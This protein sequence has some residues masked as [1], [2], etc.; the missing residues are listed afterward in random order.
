M[1]GVGAYLLAVK[2][3]G[4]MHGIGVFIQANT[5]FLIDSHVKEVVSVQ[6][7][8]LTRAIDAMAGAVLFPVAFGDDVGRMAAADRLRGALSLG[9]DLVYTTPLTCCVC[10]QG[11]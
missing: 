5:L 8:R 4:G 1:R 9:G 10:G 6:A 11:C 3:S 2:L 7:L